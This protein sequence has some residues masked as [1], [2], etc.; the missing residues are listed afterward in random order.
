[1]IELSQTPMMLLLL[2]FHFQYVNNENIN[3]AILATLLCKERTHTNRIRKTVSQLYEEAGHLAERKFRMKETLFWKLHTLIKHD[4]DLKF[5]IT[6]G[7]SINRIDL[8]L[9]IACALCFFA[10]GSYLDIFT[11]TGIVAA[12]VYKIV[13][14]VT[15][16]VNKHN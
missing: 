15:D 14:A 13:W 1:M 4:I 16:A 3:L 10:G 8:S 7:S 12:S 5:I 6:N 11:D 9:R 2:L